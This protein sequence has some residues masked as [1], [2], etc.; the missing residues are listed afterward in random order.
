MCLQILGF[1]LARQYAGR[2]QREFSWSDIFH[3]WS[4]R[5]GHGGTASRPLLTGR[6]TQAEE[7]DEEEAGEA[8]QEDE[9]RYGST[10]NGRGHAGPRIEPS[11][12]QP[13]HNEWRDG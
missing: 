6:V 11:G 2:F 8:G 5:D 4:R 9:R 7:A 12:L 13:E 1:V 3:Q 10:E